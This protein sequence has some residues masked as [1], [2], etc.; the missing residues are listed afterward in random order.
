MRPLPRRSPAQR[1]SARAFAPPCRHRSVSLSP[2]GGVGSVASPRLFCLPIVL[3]RSD[4]AARASR[5]CRRVSSAFVFFFPPPL[6]SPCQPIPLGGRGRFTTCRPHLPQLLRLASRVPHAS[7][8]HTDFFIHLAPPLC[9]LASS[10]SPP[11][12]FSFPPRP[13]RRIQLDHAPLF[14]PRPCFQPTFSPRSLFLFFIFS[15]RLLAGNVPV[16]S[17]VRR[18]GLANVCP[19]LAP[20]RSASASLAPVAPLL[21]LFSRCP[22]RPLVRSPHLVHFCAACRSFVLSLDGLAW[23]TVLHRVPCKSNST[24]RQS[25]GGDPRPREPPA[26]RL[27]RRRAILRPPPHTHLPPP[28]PPAQA[29]PLVVPVFALAH[30][31]LRRSVARP[32]TRAASPIRCPI[33]HT[34]HLVVHAFTPAHTPP[35][36][37]FAAP[38]HR[39]AARSSPAPTRSVHP[40]RIWP[41]KPL[42]V[43]RSARRLFLHPCR[44]FPRLDS[45]HA[46]YPVATAQPLCRQRTSTTPISSVGCPARPPTAVS[47]GPLRRVRAPRSAPPHRIRPLKMHLFATNPASLP[48]SRP[49]A[50]LATPP[51]AVASIQSTSL[52][53]PPPSRR[54][55]SLLPDLDAL[56]SAFR[57]IRRSLFSPHASCT[58]LTS[59]VVDPRTQR[60][61]AAPSDR[62]AHRTGPRLPN[63]SR[64]LDHPPSSP[65]FYPSIL[66]PPHQPILCPHTTAPRSA[67]CL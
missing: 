63:C 45:A 21:S 48:P 54:S 26:T 62:A 61:R 31:P 10:F 56:R 15:P 29:R 64:W 8:K 32:Q 18:R 36:R 14:P 6:P 42:L 57:P 43:A 27:A 4:V 28:F 41:P 12:F 51:A 37:A 46:R 23:C 30:A 67:L 50:R 53:P 2:C 59:I 24:F 19:S 22:S 34:S 38:T 1:A 16:A 66:V 52:P 40:A 55:L 60:Q 65:F 39:F 44:L 7:R 47:R 11:F 13:P 5:A 3:L 49:C 25:P 35:C 9:S 58:S 20:L 17:F 33:A